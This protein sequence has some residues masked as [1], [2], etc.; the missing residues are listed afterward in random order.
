MN[1][2]ERAALA[3]QEIDAAIALAEKATPGPWRNTDTGAANVL[4]FPDQPNRNRPEFDG[5][6]YM[7]TSNRHNDA[8]FIAASRTLLP[9]SLRCL[10][11]AIEGLLSAIAVASPL[12]EE[13]LT[14]GLTTLCDQ[15]EAGRK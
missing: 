13:H 15:W 6:L 2:T 8:A 12:M 4:A 1:I 5:A 3:L 9:K 10:K 14:A 7:H 11:T